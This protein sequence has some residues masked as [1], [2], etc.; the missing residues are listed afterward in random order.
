MITHVIKERLDLNAAFANH[1]A[2]E[3]HRLR[4]PG[5]YEL[6]KLARSSFYY[7]LPS[8]TTVQLR[9]QSDLSDNIE[10]I[11]LEFPGCGYQRVTKQLEHDLQ[12]VNNKKVLR[13]IW[14]SDSLY[15]MKPKKV[16]TTNYKQLFSVHPN[17]IKSE[18]I[19]WVNKARL[20]PTLPI[21]VSS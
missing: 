9:T 16:K 13:F 10:C 11:C 2:V 15:R 21:I 5:G 8:K 19:S 7:E 12:V 3:S 4:R 14:E 1:L 18:M 17:L 6:M 20:E